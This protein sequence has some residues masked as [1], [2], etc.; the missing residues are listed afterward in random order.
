MK[1][2]LLNIVVLIT[3]LLEGCSMIK[4]IITV[5]DKR[6][7]I[8]QSIQLPNNIKLT[9]LGAVNING[10]LEKCAGFWYSKADMS[11]CFNVPFRAGVQ[12]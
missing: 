10:S 4:I 1:R 6:D 3:I 5:S 7:P 9:S 2:I 11:P 8:S 12:R